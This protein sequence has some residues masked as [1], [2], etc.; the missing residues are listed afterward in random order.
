MSRRNL[1]EQIAKQNQLAIMLMGLAFM[2][3]VGAFWAFAHFAPVERDKVSLC[4]KSIRLATQTIIIVDRT[5]P[6]SDAQGHLLSIAIRREATRLKPANRFS[7]IA[8]DGLAKQHIPPLFDRCHPGTG[9]QANPLIATPSRIDAIFER[10]FLKPLKLAIATATHAARAE[11]TYLVDFISHVAAEAQYSGAVEQINIVIFSDMAE[12]SD[13]FSIY[14]AS[15][16]GNFSKHFVRHFNDRIGDRMS[17]VSL[18]VHQ[19]AHK[20][21]SSARRKLVRKAWI[22]ALNK[23]NVSF[24]WKAF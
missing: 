1:K 3:L 10:S 18:S 19:L 24:T 15:R 8:F 5:D 20:G 14:R 7:L 17:N 16:R 11:K 4:P 22:T 21:Q 13:A 12:N 2:G 23:R 9:A 6:W